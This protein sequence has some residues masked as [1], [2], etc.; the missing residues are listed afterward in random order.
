M[1]FRGNVYLTDLGNAVGSVQEGIRPC[2]VMSN[3]TNNLHSPIIQ[4]IP[5]TTS[6]KTALPIHYVL[7]SHIYKFLDKDSV[8]LVEQF[9]TISKEQ[10]IRYIGSL[11]ESDLNKILTRLDIQLGRD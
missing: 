9:T 8:A 5:L 2:I 7:K 10:I 11:N 3:N 1:V 6:E 4:V